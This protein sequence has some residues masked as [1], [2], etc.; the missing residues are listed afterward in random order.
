MMSQ[1]VIN[2]ALSVPKDVL[3][4]FWALFVSVPQFSF[5]ILLKDYSYPRKQF[6]TLSTPLAGKQNH[7]QAAWMYWPF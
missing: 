7:C 5:S 4:G 6:I 1:L 2:F 3:G